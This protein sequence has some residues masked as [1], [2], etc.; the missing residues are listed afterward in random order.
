MAA[1]YNLLFAP[2]TVIS[3]TMVLTDMILAAA[4]KYFTAATFLWP[5]A[6]SFHYF[7]GSL[8]YTEN[9]G[10]Y[11]SS[12]P[13]SAELMPQ[14]IL[15]MTNPFSN[16]VKKIFTSRPRRHHNPEQTPKLPSTHPT[17]NRLL[18]NATNFLTFLLVSVLF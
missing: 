16:V 8:C 15:A 13:D 12:N 1:G 17:T 18:C 11:F 9:G 7:T 6:H 2:M 3:L 10:D 4:V 14:Y 5:T